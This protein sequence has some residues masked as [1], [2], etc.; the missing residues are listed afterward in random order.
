M[1]RLYQWFSERASFFRA[2]TSGTS[3]GRTVCTEVTVRQEGTTV[4]VSGGS[5]H[6]CPLCGSDLAPPQAAQ[7]IERLLKGPVSLESGVD[8]APPGS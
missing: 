5:F 6:T 2:E 8:R 3:N 7:V 4:L 1:K